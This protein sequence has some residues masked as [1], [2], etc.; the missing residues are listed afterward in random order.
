M[1]SRSFPH[2]WL[3]T[4]FVSRLTRRV[5]LVE[6]KLLTLPEHLSSPSVFSGVRFTR[7][8]VLCVSFVDHCLSFVFLLSCWL[9]FF[10]IWILITSLWHLQTLLQLSLTIIMKFY[11]YFQLFYINT[12]LPNCDT[13]QIKKYVYSNMHIGCCADACSR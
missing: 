13:V 12:V 6:Q 4:G 9:L 3:I 7:S 11:Y 5:S 2:S 8:L 1:T 10:D